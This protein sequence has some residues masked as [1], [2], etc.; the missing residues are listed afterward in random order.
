MNRTSYIALVLLATAA[1]A[2]GADEDATRAPAGQA[3]PST[4]QPSPQP[5]DPWAVSTSGAGPVEVGARLAELAPMLAQGSDTVALAGGCAYVQIAEAPAGLGFM[6]EDGRIVRVDVDSGATPTR[7]GAR[8]GDTE[9][10]IDSLYAPLRRTPHKYTPG[11]SYLVA[12]PDAPADTMSRLVFET[13][14]MVVR[15]YRA[16]VYPPVEYVE[17]CG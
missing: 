12:L 17:R 14:G 8:I 9:Q 10:R 5:V 4:Q 11:W 2:R 3:S 16:G 13:D 6:L 1:C 7:E 15:A